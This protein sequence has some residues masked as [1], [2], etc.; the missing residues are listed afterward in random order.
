M[1]NL[2]L[3]PELVWF[4]LGFIFF[5]MELIVP[6]FVIFFFG[7]GAWIAA[8][9][10]LL[11]PIG[12]NFQIFIFIVASIATLLA[13]RKLL[14]RQ[15]FTNN[16]STTEN[17]D[18][19]ITGNTATAVSSFK[20]GETGKVEFRG[21]Y[22]NASSLHNIEKGQIVTIIGKQSTTLIVEPK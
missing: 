12:T 18:D 3:H 20:I 22:W 9:L 1:G 5:V 13:F 17:I 14:K 7:V 2:W 19:D 15:F 10:A 6:G 21:S 4:I 16:D 8:L 11:L